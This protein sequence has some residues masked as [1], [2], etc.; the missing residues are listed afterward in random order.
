MP[1]ANLLTVNTYDEAVDMVQTN[2]V[3]AMISD[4]H[5]CLLAISRNPKAG[6]IKKITPFTYE[7]LGIA[8]PAGDA[9][10]MNWTNNFLNTMQ[11]SGE[12]R[13]LK[14]KWIKGT[15]WIRRLP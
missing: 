8:L 15:S 10:L 9:H 12:L 4:Y 7:P 3:D 6:F 14:A 2:E 13:G 5:T 11:A 1:R